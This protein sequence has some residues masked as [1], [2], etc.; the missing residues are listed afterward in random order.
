[1]TDL[2]NLAVDNQHPFGRYQSPDGCLGEVNSGLWHNRAYAAKIDV[3]S[4][5]PKF[6]IG[7]IL[8]CDKTG[9]SVQHNFETT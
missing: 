9:T 6:L 3:T 8:Y 4:T 2:N 7:I 5:I 1:M